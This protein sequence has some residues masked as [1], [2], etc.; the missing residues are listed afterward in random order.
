[1]EIMDTVDKKI[2][3]GD[4]AYMIDHNVH[5]N[6]NGPLN[7]PKVY[8]VIITKHENGLYDGRWT[9]G[10][11]CFLDVPEKLVYKT[12]V[13]TNISNFGLDIDYVDIYN[14]VISISN[15]N[16]FFFESDCYDYD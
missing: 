11:G 9:K 10:P 8:E 13:D 15:D 12:E 1:M 14:P 2:K 7:E 4:I 3:V 16:L 6:P 5:G